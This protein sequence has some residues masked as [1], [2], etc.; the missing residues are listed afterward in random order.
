MQFKRPHF[1]NATRD[2]NHVTYAVDHVSVPTLGS[3]ML[4]DGAN[5]FAPN[6]LMF[7][8]RKINKT[9]KMNDTSIRSLCVSFRKRQ[10]M[11]QIETRG[12]SAK[13]FIER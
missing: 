11:N 2:A 9:Q 1:L 5:R 4:A 3:A 13:I 10:S 12:F 6:G 8:L 7:I